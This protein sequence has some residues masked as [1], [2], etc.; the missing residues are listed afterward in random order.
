[1]RSRVLY[2]F[3]TPPGVKVGRTAL[4]EEVL[5]QIERANPAIEFDWPRILKGQGAPG[6]A[7]PRDSG[8]DEWRRQPRPSPPRRHQPDPPAAASQSVA[9]APAIVRNDVAPESLPP[10]AE[11]A[12]ASMLVQPELGG[13]AAAPEPLSPAHAKLGA[14]AVQR[15][16]GRYNEIVARIPER[17]PDATR[18]E[19]LN[20]LAARLNPDAWLNDEHVGRALEEY[21]IVLASLRE[22]VGGGR[23]RRGRGVKSVDEPVPSES[24][25]D[26][27][28]GPADPASPAND[29]EEGV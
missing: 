7:A 16:R 28:E 12:G 13:S 27:P 24:T 8:R 4:D 10:V 2:W 19:E 3:R 9:P 22:V 29:E 25:P 15:L 6:D 20:A 11:P 1:M 17:V 23:Q 26:G 5:R 21:E 18:Q 14:E